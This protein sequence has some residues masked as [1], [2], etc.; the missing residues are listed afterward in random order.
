[1]LRSSVYRVAQRFIVTEEMV[2]S[3]DS[4]QVMA[5]L[6]LDNEWPQS[7]EVPWCSAFTNYVAWI[8]RLCR[9]KDLRARSWLR[10][11]T[12]IA[13]DQAIADC[14]VVILKR[15]GGEQPG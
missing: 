3:I 2:G 8:L 15:G 1:M 6:K 11:G 9:S 13:L 10:V 14:D 4:P 7:D 5:M 12:P